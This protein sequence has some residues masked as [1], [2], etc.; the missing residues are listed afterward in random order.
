MGEIVIGL[1]LIIFVFLI[2]SLILGGIKGAFE[3][4][5]QFFDD[6]FRK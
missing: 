4:Y 1:F 3:I 2:G 5:S 6:I